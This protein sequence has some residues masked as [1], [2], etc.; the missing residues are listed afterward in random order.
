MAVKYVDFKVT[1]DPTMARATAERA[2][3]DRKFKITWTDDWSGLAER[4]NKV[5]N[6]IVGALAQYFKVGLSL[7][8]AGPTETIVRVE[9]LSS[10]WAG[11]A[12]GA[13]RT[14]RNF[15]NL[16]SELEATFAQA[17]VLIDVNEG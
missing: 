13:S 9:R 4:G 14:T 3:A 7:M 6:L 8:S 15:S 1:G 17:G 12:I 2:L 16:K 5:A 11:G 10:G